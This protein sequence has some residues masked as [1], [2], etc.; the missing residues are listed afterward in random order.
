M[1][2][3][4]VLFLTKIFLFAA[5]LFFTLISWRR[6]SE[7]NFSFVKLTLLV[8]SYCLRLFLFELL[9]LC[10]KVSVNI[11]IYCT[12]GQVFHFQNST[13]KNYSKIISSESCA[14][15]WANVGPG[16]SNSTKMTRD[17]LIHDSIV[18]VRTK[19]IRK[20]MFSCGEL[21]GLFYFMITRKSIK[22]FRVILTRICCFENLDW[23][24]DMRYVEITQ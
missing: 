16:L 19:T 18:N 5:K 8:S 2:A 12:M 20:V 23:N 1:D 4:L 21:I 11:Q 17:N 7:T 22:K 9:V 13:Y 15:R 6:L 14:S 10:M 3:V 24:I